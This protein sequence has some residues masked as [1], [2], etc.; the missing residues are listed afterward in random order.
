MSS[1]G[2]ALHCDHRS[3]FAQ[4]LADA[5]QEQ[6]NEGRRGSVAYDPDQRRGKLYPCNKYVIDQQVLTMFP[7][8]SAASGNA[9]RP[10]NERRYSQQQPILW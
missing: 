9:A 8:G 1:T 4:K 10:G 5:R 2:R 6:Q 3:P 7:T